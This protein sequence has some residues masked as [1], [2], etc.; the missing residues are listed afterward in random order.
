MRAH[1][2]SN[3]KKKDGKE[4]QSS[5]GYAKSEHK[6][7]CGGGLDIDMKEARISTAPKNYTKWPELR[8]NKNDTN[9]TATP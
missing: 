7:A 8:K 1:F 6:T 3:S 9:S 2:T 4:N 5:R